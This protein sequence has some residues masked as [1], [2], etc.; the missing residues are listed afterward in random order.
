MYGYWIY[1]L[2]T[3]SLGHYANQK[4]VYWQFNPL[5]SPESVVKVCVGFSILC[6]HINACQHY[7]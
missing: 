2:G 5:S 4:F 3:P 7:V 6:M 1:G